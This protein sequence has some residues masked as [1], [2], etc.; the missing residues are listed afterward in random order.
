MAAVGDP[1]TPGHAQPRKSVWQRVLVWASADLAAHP[2]WD[3]GAA[4]LG[5]WMEEG[6]G[7]ASDQRA[8]WAA[9][10]SELRAKR[11]EARVRHD[12]A[13]KLCA[14]RSTLCEAWESL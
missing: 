11:S 9:V 10:E 13:S 6:F 4:P 1:A 3:H 5:L 14:I 7:A 8:L 12:V 2:E